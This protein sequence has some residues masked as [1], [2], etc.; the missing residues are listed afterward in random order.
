MVVTGIDVSKAML[1]VSIA[2]GSVHRFENSD[3]GLR[4]W[5]RHRDRAGTTQAGRFAHM[6]GLLQWLPTH[7]NFTSLDRYGG[8][9][10]SRWS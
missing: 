5:L 10:A 6:T 9:L 7:V 1:D 2:E 4:R 3:P 8:R